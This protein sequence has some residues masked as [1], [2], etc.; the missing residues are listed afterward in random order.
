[1]KIYQFHE[2]SKGLYDQL[3]RFALRGGDLEAHDLINA[4]ER[5]H[6]KVVDVTDDKVLL[7][8]SKDK[9]RDDKPAGDAQT[10]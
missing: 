6:L 8:I 9:I 3:K 5:E 7:L 1:M 10:G 4:F 2:D